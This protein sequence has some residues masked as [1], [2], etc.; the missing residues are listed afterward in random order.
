MIDSNTFENLPAIYYARYNKDMLSWN[1][2]C[3]CQEVSQTPRYLMQQTA[4]VV[5][6]GNLYLMWNAAIQLSSHLDV[7]YSVFTMADSWPT[8]VMIDRTYW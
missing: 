8:L 2:M 3:I 4:E 6:Q 5:H 1:W 7:S